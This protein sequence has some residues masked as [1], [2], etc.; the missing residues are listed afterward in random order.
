MAKVPPK[1]KKL[2]QAQ[3]PVGIAGD[4]WTRVAFAS[5]FKKVLSNARGQPYKG[6]IPL[7]GTEKGPK[8]EGEGE[9]E[10]G[11]GNAPSGSREEER[12]RPVQCEIGLNSP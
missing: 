11:G 8:G 3:R 5:K 7:P 9:G 2:M 10:G 6:T 4:F 12:D 1:R